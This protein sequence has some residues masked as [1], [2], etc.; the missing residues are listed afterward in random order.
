MPD[1]E[2]DI[3]VVTRVLEEDRQLAEVL[4]F[5]EDSYYGDDPGE[6][7]RVLQ[8][9]VRSMLRDLPAL[10]VH[11]RQLP[12]I[13]QLRQLAVSVKAREKSPAWQRPVELVFHL[14]QW[15]HGDRPY[16]VFVPA[17][18]IEVIVNREE[19][20]ERRVEAGIQFALMRMGTVSSLPG[21]LQ[22]HRYQDTRID[23]LSLPAKIRTPKQRDVDRNKPSEKSR[24]PEVATDMAKAQHAQAYEL[25][26]VLHHMADSLT[27]KHSSSVLLVGPAGVGKT[28]AV[29]ELVRQRR[30]L[31][32]S[33][34]Q[35][36]AT[37]GARLVSGTSGFGMW[38]ERCTELCREVSKQRAILYLGNLIELMEVGKGEGDTMGLA[39][40]LAPY[41]GR[42]EILVIAECTTEQV[43]T[44]EQ[45][46]P[47]LLGAF[48]Q[49]NIEPPTREKCRSILQ[50]YATALHRAG[51]A[52]ISGEALDELE[53]LHRRYAT[54][55]AQPG[56]A[57]RFLSNLLCDYPRDRT[58]Q[59]GDVTR[60]FS[61][62]TGLPDIILDD[63]KALD[64]DVT[65]QWFGEHIMGQP[66]AIDLSVDLLATAKLGLSR[67]QKPLASLL[68]IGPTG[69]GKTEMAK[70]LA[71]FLFGERRRMI[72][73]D[74]SEYADPV[75][76]AQL[77]GGQFGDEG[78]LTA[79]VREQPFSV[80]LLDEFE[81]AHPACFDLL[82][83]IL[84]EGRLTD[85]S[86]RL[87]N[88]CN[89][90]VIMTSNLGAASFQKGSLGFAKNRVLAK[91][92]KQHFVE[93]VRRHLRPELFNRIDRIVPFEPL[94]PETV[95]QIASRELAK[96]RQRDGIRLRGVDLNMPD[97][98][99]QY[100]AEKG[101]D[102]RYGARPLQ[103]V[104]ERE[105]LVPLADG[106]NVCAPELAL[107]ADIRV[108]GRQ[109]AVKV[110]ALE[111]GK[112]KPMPRKE[113]SSPGKARPAGATGL[114]GRH[115]TAR[116]ATQRS[117]VLRRKIQILERSSL[118]RD[119]QNDVY[120]LER[121]KDRLKRK[122][123]PSHHL[124]QE[125]QE[126]LERLPRLQQGA[127]LLNDLA[128]E[129]ATLEDRMLTALYHPDTCARPVTGRE[130]TQA[131]Q[132]Y[133]ELLLALC[134]LQF[135]HPDYVTLAIFGEDSASVLVLASAYCDI[136]RQFGLG[137]EAG[138]FRPPDKARRKKDELEQTP[139]AKLEQFL[140]KPPAKL[141]GVALALTGPT[142]Y[143]RFELEG[144]THRFIKKAG[145]H[146]CLVEVSELALAKYVPPEG[147][148]RA[149]AISA[150]NIRRSYDMQDKTIDDKT[151]KQTFPWSGDISGILGRVIEQNL[152]Q[153]I[154]SL[155]AE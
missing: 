98:V 31:G 123:K 127:R 50:R 46:D 3:A 103:R 15:S 18:G 113:E 116:V 140:A 95:R 51:H 47:R 30:S 83:Q 97:S 80:V 55:S 133:D 8:K 75:S 137:V 129:V 56:R 60:A 132:H 38:Q 104:I 69:V 4:L 45:E 112:A 25:E 77:I 21:L 154:N 102:P 22:L 36:W 131:E 54:Y 86:G 11:R 12:T 101:Y 20:L 16:L 119:L 79:Q 49:I 153:N 9:N 110:R 73:F 155:V 39:G 70:T 14:V 71:K 120:A 99:V 28:A 82:L 64:L 61:R 126:S 85:A 150:R 62:G 24:L 84:G 67:P 143:P 139:I 68:F 117:T 88:F 42:G 96:I 78:L 91:E 87:A 107:C 33:Q 26:D 93:E 44:I 57:I 125:E 76:V 32:L 109:L 35:F 2:F 65:R 134:A 121:I 100:L 23:T 111:P 48:R 151:L 89:C 138:Q 81:K 66:E 41:I 5:P 52:S 72:R 130:L 40:F 34:T 13:P 135:K 6:L 19:D 136:A 27:G 128:Q 122:K 43:S 146:H 94:S 74:M 147:I 145:K 114:P 144:G 1:I 58:V 63:A 106:A 59:P 148:D 29:F 17:L 53:R 108:E 105:L 92:A 7:R 90:V 142:A 124:K 141:L 10:D 37:S 152:S 118:V 149:R 115:L